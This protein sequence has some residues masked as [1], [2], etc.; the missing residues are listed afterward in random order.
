MF[1]FPPSQSLRTNAQ[2][3][4]SHG[5]LVGGWEIVMSKF[6]H[7]VADKTYPLQINGAV[8]NL[9]LVKL[10]IKILKTSLSNMIPRASKGGLKQIG[11]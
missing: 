6:C 1:W 7:H 9:E 11:N 10:Q 5:H 2:T 4:F 3:E 8:E